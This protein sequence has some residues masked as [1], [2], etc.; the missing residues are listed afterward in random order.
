RTPMDELIRCGAVKLRQLLQRRELST[1][2]AVE[3]HIARI[4]LVNGSLNAVVVPLFEEALAE[5]KAADELA[6]QGE[7]LGPLHGLPITVKES[8]DLRGTAS[9][10]GVARWLPIK[11]RVDADVVAALRRAG[12]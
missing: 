11:A 10:A 2:Q 5:A 8:L 9:T 3:A 4:E 7:W 12:A 6:A 1:T